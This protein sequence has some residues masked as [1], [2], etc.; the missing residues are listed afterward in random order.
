ML[1]GAGL[2]AQTLENPVGDVRAVTC[3]PD[4]LPPVVV[5]S[6]CGSGGCRGRCRR[7]MRSPIVVG[8]SHA[9]TA[10]SDGGLIGLALE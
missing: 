8:E 2:A 7:A 9:Y 5:A 1:S 3:S 6:D 10:A 4:R